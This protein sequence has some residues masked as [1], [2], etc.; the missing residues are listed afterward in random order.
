[1][2]TILVVVAIA[3]VI[4]TLYW[5]WSRKMTAELAESAAE[6][7]ER[8]G[9]AEPE[10][11]AGI[12][13]ARFRALFHRVHFPRFPKYALLSLA[14]F[15]VALPV[16]LAVLA[17]I[18]LGLDHAGLSADT[19]ALARSIPVAGATNAV[20]RD[21]NET[22]AFYYVQAVLKFYYYFGLLFAWLAVVFIAMRRFHKHRPGHLRD[23]LAQEKAKR[24]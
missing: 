2:T 5:R 18:A 3:A 9:R 12:D 19:A 11:V 23:E 1:M 20:T 7:F 6:E 4:A 15:I 14:A 21:Q 13:E 22:I 16:T 8:L 24:G 17:A 10:L